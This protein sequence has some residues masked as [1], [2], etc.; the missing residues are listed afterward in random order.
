MLE[1]KKTRLE[2]WRGI[3]RY[4]EDFLGMRKYAKITLQFYRNY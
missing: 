1:I 4:C 3:V 2:V